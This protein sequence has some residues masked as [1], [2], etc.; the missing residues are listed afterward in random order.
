[1]I[2]NDEK[3]ERNLSFGGWAVV[4]CSVRG[5]FDSSKH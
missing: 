5:R 2:K 4:A 1:M 3:L